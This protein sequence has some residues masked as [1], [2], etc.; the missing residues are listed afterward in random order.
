MIQMDFYMKSTMYKFIF[1][2]DKFEAK[3][4]DKEWNDDK[5]EAIRQ[6][7]KDKAIKNYVFK[8][9]KNQEELNKIPLSIKNKLK[10]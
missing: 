1:K 7:A 6:K 5:E 9:K 8:H 10:L 3:K 4:E 2:K